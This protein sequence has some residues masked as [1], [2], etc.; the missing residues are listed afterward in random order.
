MLTIRPKPRFA[1]ALSP[2]RRAWTYKRGTFVLHGVPCGSH[3]LQQSVDWQLELYL[4][5]LARTSMRP[6]RDRAFS[7]QTVIVLRAL[8]VQPA[9]WRYGY[10]LG[11]EV[12]L[13]SGS[14]Y[15]ILM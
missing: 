11:V 13:K 9:A 3:R 8:A 10:E 6:R 12:G 5:R 14:L 4:G 2:G 7:A 1:D 15:P